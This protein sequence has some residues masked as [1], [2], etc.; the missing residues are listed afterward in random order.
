M[1]TEQKLNDFGSRAFFIG[2]V[3]VDP[4]LQRVTTSDGKSSS[5]SKRQLTAIVELAE[6]YGAVVS[7]ARMHEILC[8][9]EEGLR[10]RGALS[11]HIGI[12]RRAF[13]DSSKQPIFIKTVRGKGY[14]LLAK[15]MLA[16][17][18]Q[19]LS[20]AEVDS[21][22]AINRA[23]DVE[24]LDVDVKNS[25]FWQ[26][27]MNRNVG[28]V[29][30]AISVLAIIVVGLAQPFGSARFGTE[31]DSHQNN[32]AQPVRSAQ[33]LA[34]VRIDIDLMKD[35]QAAGQYRQ[36]GVSNNPTIVA[37]NHQLQELLSNE[38][39]S[40]KNKSEQLLALGDALMCLQQ[41]ETSTRALDASLSIQRDLEIAPNP[42]RLAYTLTR[43]AQIRS[44]VAQNIDSSRELILEAAQLL[45][46]QNANNVQ[47]AEIL[48]IHAALLEFDSDFVGAE[49]FLNEALDIASKDL[50]ED[51][52]FVRHLQIRLAKVFT[53]QSNFGDAETLTTS[54]LRTQRNIL[55]VNDPGL[56]PILRQLG[57]LLAKQGD[58]NSAARQ[59]E[60]VLAILNDSSSPGT[61][62]LLLHTKRSLA[63]ALLEAGYPEQA[64]S[65]YTDVINAVRLRNRAGPLGLSDL[66]LG[67]SDA[68]IKA[69]KPEQAYEEIEHA[70]VLLEDQQRV[71]DWMRYSANSLRGA[72][73]IELGHCAKGM[74]L[75]NNT[76]DE[77]F[78][79]RVTD[80]RISSKIH[81]R[82]NHYETSR[83]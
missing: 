18:K 33:E 82:K 51:H 7:R 52:R 1:P 71:P 8:L 73:L 35:A 66:K 53:L 50:S 6:H 20:A 43:L 21:S 2:S 14:Y 63:E 31:F 24:S 30:T 22:I 9:S 34:D 57:F 46:S 11:Q 28:R 54:I 80:P 40:V 37:L 25:A 61:T 55:P 65:L 41:W 13:G 23:N 27:L 36:V 10:D 26:G 3:L 59:Y 58:H 81:A 29:S 78:L 69:K 70:M 5:V 62:S 12:I 48:S 75:L 39:I 60:E 16:S 68:L 45:R 56:V 4:M 76:I 38:T 15:P 44:V 47:H 74:Q 17:K 77:M 32:E 72:A 42:T 64:I 49:N 83:C 67:L 79:D 19:G